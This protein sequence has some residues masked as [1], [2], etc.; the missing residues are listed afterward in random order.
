MAISETG[1]LLSDLAKSG[2]I[3]RQII[4][5]NVMESEDCDFCKARKAGQLPYLREIGQTFNQLSRTEVPL[6]AKEMKGLNALNQLGISLFGNH[7]S[8]S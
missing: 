6:F 4:V 8:K 2:I 7:S 1:R 5:N 3:A